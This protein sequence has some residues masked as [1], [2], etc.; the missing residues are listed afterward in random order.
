MGKL[1]RAIE[2]PDRILPYV[3]EQWYG[4]WK[5]RTVRLRT[6]DGKATL[7]LDHCDL[8]VDTTDDGIGR[9]LLIHG[10]HEPVSSAV[11]RRELRALAADID[12]TLTVFDLGANI[13]YHALMPAVD[14]DDTHVYA[15]EADAGNYALLRRNIEMNGLDEKFTTDCVA[16][17]NEKGTAQFHV[18]TKSNRH[19]LS[20]RVT[21]A[22]P[23]H[24]FRTRSV[25]LRDAGAWLAEQGLS[26]ADLHV[27]RMD[28]EG[29]E[30]E[31]FRSLDGLLSNRPL[32][33]HVEIHPSL[34]D[35]EDT[36]YLVS[37]L[38]QADLELVAASQNRSALSVTSLDEIRETKWVETVLKG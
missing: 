26:P 28:I 9:T 8:T 37:R 22:F 4:P 18:S 29:W 30:A 34:M 24:D 3:R 21:E 33:L 11:Y 15:V 35:A 38:A 5:L 1:A 6:D 2:R 7:E 17:G 32:L 10:R 23:S 12:E 19:S 25:D 36:D 20:P 16:L 14:I 27:L 13:G 31:V